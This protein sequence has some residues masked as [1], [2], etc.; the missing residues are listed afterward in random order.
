MKTL[1]WNQAAEAD[2]EDAPPLFSERANATR[3]ILLDSNRARRG[4]QGGAGSLVI[5]G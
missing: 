1:M 4:L 2:V 5:K 3:R